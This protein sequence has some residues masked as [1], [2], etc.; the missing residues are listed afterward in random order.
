MPVEAHDEFACVA[1]D[2][3][4]ITD[5]AVVDVLVV[6]ILDLHDLVTGGEGPAEPLDFPVVGGIESGLIFNVD[7]SGAEP[8]AVDRAENLD[9]ADGVE[10]EPPRD[11][12]LDQLD[13]T[14]HRDLGLFDRHE[15]EIAFGSWRSEIGNSSLIDPMRIGDDAAL[16]G[17][18]KYLGETNNRQSTGCDD[19]R[20]HLSGA[21]RWKLVDGADDQQRSAVRHRLQQRLHQH[22]VDHRGLVDNQQVAVERVVVAPLEAATFRIDLQQ[23]VDGLGFEA[24]CFA[25]ALGGAAGRRAEQEPYP[26]GGQYAQNSFDDSGLADA[27]TAGNHQHLGHQGKLDGGSLAFRKGEPDTCFDPWQGLFRID[28]RPRQWTVQ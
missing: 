8:A 13:N 22:D 7:R 17:L 2:S 5:V 11:P 10:A 12:G 18:A 16:R 28:P 24:G 6:V 27:G 19:V 1:I 4:D 23:P 14:L 26:L 20:Q 21:D 15:V 9:V 25:H 3:V